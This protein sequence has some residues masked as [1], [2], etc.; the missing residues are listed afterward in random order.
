MDNGI[1]WKKVAV[2][3][4][5]VM[6]GVVYESRKK[7]ALL[8][9]NGVELASARWGCRCAIARAWAARSARGWIYSK[10]ICPQGSRR[11]PRSLEFGGNDS[12]TTGRR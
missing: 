3:G 11:M 5:S 8:P 2:W 7:Y 9:E 4:D 6:K 1:V 12:I 10:R